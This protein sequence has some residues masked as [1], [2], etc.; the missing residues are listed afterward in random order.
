MVRGYERTLLAVV[1]PGTLQ[2]GDDWNAAVLHLVERLVPS[3]AHMHEVRWAPVGAMVLDQ[4]K[5]R[6][7]V[8]ARTGEH[9]G[10]DPGARRRSPD[11]RGT[12]GKP[13]GS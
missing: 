12:L 1:D 6:T 11:T 8:I 9:H 3:E 7:E 5:T 2:R 10:F 4:V 13:F